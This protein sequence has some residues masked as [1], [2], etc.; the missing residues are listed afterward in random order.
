MDEL[1][2]IKG[3][4]TNDVAK[5]YNH[6]RKEFVAANARTVLPQTTVLTVDAGARAEFTN[7]AECVSGLSGSGAVDIGAGSSLGVSGT[8]GFSGTVSG[9]GT[10]A[11]G[12]NLAWAVDPDVVGDHAF[13]AV[14][15]GY[16][17][18]DTSKWTTVPSLPNRTKDWSVKNGRVVLTLG[19]PGVILLLK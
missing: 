13:F 10:L 17:L 11:L 9:A 8:I 12:E 15:E 2:V 4:D 5:M 7:A 1:F 18:P 6:R 14:P 16:V 3:A 19:V